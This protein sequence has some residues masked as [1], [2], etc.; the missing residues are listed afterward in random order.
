[1]PSARGE[2]LSD[3]VCSSSIRAFA[4]LEQKAEEPVK[5]SSGPSEDSDAVTKGRRRK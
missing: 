5:I 1:M 4:E 3:C 2:E